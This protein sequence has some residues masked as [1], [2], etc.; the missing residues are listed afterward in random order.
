MM[1]ASY[2][3]ACLLETLKPFLLKPAMLTDVSFELS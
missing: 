2:N 3:L 1:Q